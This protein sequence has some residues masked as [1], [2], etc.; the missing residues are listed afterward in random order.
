MISEKENIQ[1]EFVDTLL[2]C[3][4]NQTKNAFVKKFLSSLESEIVKKHTLKYNV[5]E[6][7]NEL[8][9]NCHDELSV[10]IDLL[11]ELRQLEES[12]SL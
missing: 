4:L 10:Y 1:E 3:E 6:R 12:G 9:K 2:L 8:N 7:Y 11:K 5:Y